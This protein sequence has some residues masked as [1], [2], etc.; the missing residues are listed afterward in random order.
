MINKK[1]ILLFVVILSSITFTQNQMPCSDP[2]AGQFDFWIGTWSLTWDAGEGKTETGTNEVRKI[3]NG[4][5]VEENFNSESIEFTGKS[6]SV[7]SIKEKKW[8]QTWVDN[9]GNY[10]DFEG[11]M[12]SDKMILSRNLVKDGKPMKQR[13]VFYNIEDDS[14][15]WSWESSLN[16]GKTWEVKWLIHYKRKI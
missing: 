7:Y 2:E 9:R 1:G 4:C 6:F 10:L 13:M 14:F 3:L 12:E 5:V 8:L 11:G 16:D 15:D